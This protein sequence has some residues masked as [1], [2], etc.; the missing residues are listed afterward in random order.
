MGPN[1]CC[2]DSG[3]QLEGRTVSLHGAASG[4]LKADLSEDRILKCE[5]S[6][7][8]KYLEYSNDRPGHH[9]W[10]HTRDQL[11]PPRRT[12]GSVRPAGVG[13]ATAQVHRARGAR[14]PLTRGR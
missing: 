11:E 6:S 9:Y 14:G 12:R 7:V 8:L 5:D 3:Q 1:L 2:R 4:S 13:A 10:C